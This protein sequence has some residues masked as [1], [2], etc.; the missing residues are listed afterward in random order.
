MALDRDAVLTALKAVTDPVT[1]QDIVAAGVVRALNVDGDAVRFVVE[2][3]P[4]K[5]EAYGPVRQAAE[6]AVK[7]LGAASVSAVMTAHSAPKPPS[8]GSL[9]QAL[10]SE[11]AIPRNFMNLLSPC[12]VFESCSTGWH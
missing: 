3:A 10:H 12:M 5:A 4:D 8:C 9:W 7:A 1:G 11:K 6:D 2:V